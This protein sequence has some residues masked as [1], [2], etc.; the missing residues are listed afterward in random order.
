MDYNPQAE[1]FAKISLSIDSLI[2][3]DY[4]A[5]TVLISLGAVIGKGSIFQMWI[6]AT[7][8]V[9]LYTLLEAI[10]V[11]YLQTVDVGGAMYVHVFGA[12]FGLAASYFFKN[13]RAI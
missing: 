6:L 4:G 1:R 12:Y 13:K 9:V 10:C 8:E 5:A 11:N 3:G 2:L 7:L